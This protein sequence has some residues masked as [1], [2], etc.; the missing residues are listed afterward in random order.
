MSSILKHTI[1]TFKSFKILN[2]SSTQMQ[3]QKMNNNNI[4]LDQSILAQN[5]ELY[6]PRANLRTTEQ[7]VRD[8][9]FSCNIGTVEHCDLV[10]TKDKETKQPQF[11]SVFIKL[12]TW[13]PLTDACAD[14]T[15]NG[16][17]K[18]H[19]SR[20]SN[21]FWVVLPNKNP[22]PR[23]HVNTSQLAA[24]TEKLFEQT[25]KMNDKAEKFQD[26]MRTTLSEM[27]QMM[28]FQQEKIDDLEFK[29][30][31]VEQEKYDL[32]SGLSYANNVNK[33]NIERLNE[34]VFGTTDSLAIDLELDQDRCDRAKAWIES[35]ELK[36][37]YDADTSFADR[38]RVESMSFDE[39]DLDQF[40]SEKETDATLEEHLF[41]MM[42]IPK[43]TRSA[44]VALD[45]DCIFSGSVPQKR[46]PIQIQSEPSQSL[47]LPEIVLK[48][49]ERAIVSRDFCGN[50]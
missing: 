30:K 11:A 3:S 50:L 5:L 29:L 16:S 41:N 9:F 43:L 20:N 4:K 36:A 2:M 28:K 21:E 34:Y 32:I 12:I 13:S 1:Q 10:V 22:L 6:I 25:E 15:K 44:S 48:N 49:P 17:I 45:D 31:T 26:E 19:L 24:S 46:E 7:Q 14:F 42:T 39:D 47:T 27:R 23:T 35:E 40:N 18:L 38:F 8:H 33:S 37:E